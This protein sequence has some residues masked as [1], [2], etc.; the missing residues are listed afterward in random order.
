MGISLSP[1]LWDLVTDVY[2]SIKSL[3]QLKHCKWPDI[4]LNLLNGRSNHF[5]HAYTHIV[6]IYNTYTVAAIK[7]KK[8]TI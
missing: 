5:A 1:W 4:W 3:L 8:L 6:H 2:T 7:S